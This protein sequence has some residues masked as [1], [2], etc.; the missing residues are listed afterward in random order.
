MHIRLQK[1]PR[2]I[3]LI[4]VMIVI[5]VLAMLAG[6]FAYSMKVEMR[7]ARTAMS[8]NE[9]EW[10]GRAGVDLARYVIITESRIPGQ[11]AHNSLN[12]KWAGGPGGTNDLLAAVSLENVPVG[13]GSI[14]VKIVDLERKVNINTVDQTTLQRA[15]DLIGVDAGSFS[16]IADSLLDWIDPDDNRHLSGAESD[17]YLSLKPPYFAKNG[18]L[19]DISELLLIRGIT[20]EMYWG[21][22][23]VRHT[24]SRYQPLPPGGP[25]SEEPLYS[26]GLVE[27]FTALSSGRININTAPLA[28]LQMIPGVDENIAAAIIQF[29]S[30]LDGVDGTEDDIPFSNVGQ[31]IN[32]PGMNPLAVQHL[33]RYCDVRSFTF[34]VHVDAEIGGVKRVYTALLR[35]AANNDL[36][37][38]KFTWE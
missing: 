27:I 23:L 20:P 10:L 25:A 31:L 30:G 38:L 14:T 37:L 1:A 33:T 5:F 16:T 21:P 17:Y 4:I 24:Y 11:G 29:R 35:R 32:I 6:G 22:A 34:E 28:T 7:L 9:L 26:V 13:N 12:Q 36:Q 18:P 19:D 8:D 2:G 3:A 15:L